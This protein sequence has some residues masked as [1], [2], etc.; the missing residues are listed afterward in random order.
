MSFTHIQ[1]SH[2]GK[3]QLEGSHGLQTPV[4]V[5]VEVVQAGDAAD[6]CPLAIK[7]MTSPA[8]RKV[9]ITNTIKIVEVFMLSHSYSVLPTQHLFGRLAFQALPSEV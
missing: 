7:N 1:A 2:P 3:P 4:G 9:N 8:T 5:L 6:A